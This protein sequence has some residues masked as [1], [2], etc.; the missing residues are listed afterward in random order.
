MRSIDR[1]TEV[2]TAFIEAHTNKEKP[3]T[4]GFARGETVPNF[5]PEDFGHNVELWYTKVDELRG[6]SE[7]ATIHFALT[8][9]RGLAQT[10]HEGLPC[11]KFTWEEWKAQLKAAFPMRLR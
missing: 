9:L 11:Y 3:A 4:S 6:W 1:L 7:E 5:N 10:W 2:M 8:K